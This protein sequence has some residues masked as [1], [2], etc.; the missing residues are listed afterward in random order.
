[1]GANTGSEPS[2]GQQLVREQCQR[3]K[4]AEH[5][6]A[7]Q[8]EAYALIAAGDQAQADRRL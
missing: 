2:R 3:R 1:V 8:G 5:G 6:Y 4:N 7:Q